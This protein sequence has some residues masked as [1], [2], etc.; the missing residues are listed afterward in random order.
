MGQ[1]Q[2][3]GVV[4][5]HLSNFEWFVPTR[6]QLIRRTVPCFRRQEKLVMNQ[7]LISNFNFR[8]M[9]S[10][11]RIKCLPS[12]CRLLGILRSS[13]SLLVDVLR[14]V[15]EQIPPLTFGNWPLPYEEKITWYVYILPEM[16][17]YVYSGHDI[18]PPR[19]HHVYITWT[20][21]VYDRSRARQNEVK[22]HMR[23]K[24][25][26]FTLSL[27]V[28]NEP[29]HW[30][31]AENRFYCESTSTMSSQTYAYIPSVSRTVCEKS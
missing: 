5:Y 20:S 23:A 16:T 29:R 22:G 7:D 19:V 31:R 21:H 18:L 17:S 28:Q 6:S 1:V 8:V 15:L 12:V 9:A 14:A 2:A 24:Y 27:Q 25:S 11:I 4:V 30:A 10:T 13:Q 26:I 3:K